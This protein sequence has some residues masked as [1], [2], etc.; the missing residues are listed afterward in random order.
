[1][2]GKLGQQGITADVPQHGRYLTFQIIAGSE[3][4]LNEVRASIKAA[5]KVV[6]DHDGVI[7]FGPQ[8]LQL[9][10]GKIDHSLSFP[11]FVNMGISIPSIS[12]DIW[13]WLRGEDPGELLH[14]GSEVI[15]LLSSHFAVSGIIDG[16][17]FKEGRDL[18]GYVDGT[19][20][21]EGQGA[22]NA[23]FTESGESYVAV[24]KWQHNLAHFA[25]LKQQD[26]DHIIGRRLSDNEELDDAPLSAHVKRTAQESFTPQAFMLRRSMPYTEGA[27]GGLIFVC[28]ANSPTPFKQQ[29]ARMVGKE[30]GVIDGLF[31]FSRPLT[32]AYYWCPGVK[33][34][35]LDLS[36]LSIQ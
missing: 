35:K 20:N 33:A 34:G 10:G 25:S 18:S 30:D 13:L 28:F 2:S 26:K 29:L 12:H 19:E 7:G 23:A 17:K 11:N 32:G 9:L 14:T 3:S 15:Q 21:P 31:R 27:D 8:V 24:Q 4:Q 5:S 16:F 1:V 6:S 22:I 36:K